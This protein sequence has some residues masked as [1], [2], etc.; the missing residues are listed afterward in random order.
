MKVL[1]TF[2]VEPEFA[3]FRKLRDFDDRRVGD[4]TVHQAQV[5]QATVDVV[6]TGMGPANAARALEVVT[7]EPHT[8]CI[9]SG[10]C[11]ALQA[12]YV[13]GD[14]IAARAVR[15]LK[16]NKTLQSS[17]GLVEQAR[18]DGAK[19]A[20]MFFTSDRIV[21]TKEEKA[22]LAP[23]ADAVDMESFAVFAVAAQKKLPAVAIRVVSDRFD[24]DMAVDFATTVD[25]RGAVKLGGVLKH[26]AS[27]PIQIPALIRL[28][29]ESKSAAQR[30]A[31]FLEAY[32]KKLSMTT[33][34]AVPEE[35][36]DVATRESR[37]VN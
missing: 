10:F 1:L 34:A 5:G 19:E 28:G 4:I 31:N 27:H 26:V 17:W 20:Q 9:C 18:A 36:V 12:R 14:I 21:S 33:H 7:V 3:P 37:K 22:R 30:L 32:I 24:Q 25:D 8:I 2:A 29:R 11:G 35:L 15:Q 13:P 6:V 16:N 23:F